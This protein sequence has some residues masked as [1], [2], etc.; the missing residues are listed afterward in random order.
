MGYCRRLVE[1]CRVPAINIMI[2]NVYSVLSDLPRETI[3]FGENN[4]S[5]LVEL[6]IRIW[7][8]RRVYRSV[9]LKV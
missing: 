2:L 3:F 9:L 7:E 5:V 1:K 8:G 4:Y 6:R